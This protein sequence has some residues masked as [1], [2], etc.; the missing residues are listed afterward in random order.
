MPWRAKKGEKP[1][2]Y[3]V[4]LSEIMLQQT[5]VATVGPYFLKFIARWPTLKRLARAQLDDVLRLWAG[6]GYYRRAKMLHACAREVM[7]KHG[8]VFPQD[9]KTLLGLPGFG[10]YT[11]A[12]VTAI[13]FGKSANVVDGNVERVMA[14]IFAVQTPLPNA[15]PELRRLAARLAPQDKCGDYAQALMDLGAKVCVPRNPKCALCPWRGQCRA[16]AKGI[17][18]ELPR[19]AEKKAKPIRRAIAFALF[20]SKGQILLQRRPAT[21]LL[22]H[23][24]GVPT[25]PWVEGKR[26]SLKKSL[27]YAPAKAE[28]VLRKGV[29]R[30]VFTHF[31]LELSVAVARTGIRIRGHWV[32]LEKLPQEALPSVMKKA[33]SLA[34]GHEGKE[35]PR[36]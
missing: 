21:G 32:A 6:L 14:R 22:A 34:S 36:A 29:V 7:E 26:I 5:T 10:P 1:D 24:M 23:M 25:S 19:R 12:A 20:N 30:H 9:E 33:V 4:W 13:A 8:G 2:P 28:W 27:A 18:G 17:Q 11:A 31:T 16:L 3:R 15:K 35:L